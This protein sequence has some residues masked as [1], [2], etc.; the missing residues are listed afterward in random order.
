VLE[1][2]LETVLGAKHAST[3]TKAFGFINLGDFLSHYPR[4]YARRGELTAISDIPLD[5]NV[6]LV[7][8]ILD[9][10][11]R[12]MRARKGSL[13]EVRITDGRSGGIVTLTFF[14]Q[15]WRA[16][17]LKPGMQ[18]IFA[19]KVSAYKGSLQLAHPDYEL[20]DADSE[21]IDE[22]NNAKKWALQP[23]PI[24]AATSSLASWQIAK[25]MSEAVRFLLAHGGVGDP[26]PERIRNEENIL[27]FTDALVKVHQP[28]E[29]KEWKKAQETLRFHEAFVLQATLVQ[30]YLLAEK[31]TATPRPAAPHG[32]LEQLDARL[33]FS[34][35]ADQQQVG[36]EISSDIEQTHPMN[37][38]VQG[39]VGSGKTVV[40]LRARWQVAD[41][42]GQ[43]VLLAPTEV[44]AAQHLRS[45]VSMLGPDLSASLMPTLVT[46]QLPAAQKR[47]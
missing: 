43:A 33:P 9:V 22:V 29:D 16:Q 18:G 15:A 45:I 8:E 7:A 38:L 31:L 41:S 47:Q 34:L 14:N 30:Q 46:G 21:A 37:R 20:F 28:D 25:L 39:E 6:T 2:P 40:A 19:G 24:Y 26:V 42:G 35:T 13:L 23:I 36:A 44:L 10:R 1:T 11:E 3:L 5:E 17:Q 27:T 12:P 4:R 32:Y